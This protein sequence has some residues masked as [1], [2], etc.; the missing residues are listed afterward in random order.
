MLAQ[1]EIPNGLLGPT[2][3]TI[4]LLLLLTVVARAWASG[5]FRRGTEFDE[6]KADYEQRL[7][8]LRADYEQRLLEAKQDREW[9]RG[10]VL[11]ALGADEQLI[12]RQRHTSEDGDRD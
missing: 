9:W 12:A 1:V 11:D 4:G 8:E 7:V 10:R 3:L 5:L 6:L 2:A